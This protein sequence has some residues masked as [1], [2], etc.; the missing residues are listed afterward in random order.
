VT[1]GNV[2]G[3]GPSSIYGLTSGVD[4]VAGAGAGAGVAI[5]GVARG[6]ELGVPVGV[7]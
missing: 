6:L 4:T 1:G 5:L 3:S 7:G 2:E